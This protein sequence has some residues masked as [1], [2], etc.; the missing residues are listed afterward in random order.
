MANDVGNIIVIIT[1]ALFGLGVIAIGVTS[2]NLNAMYDNQPNTLIV[3][4]NDPTT[5]SED[6]ETPEDNFYETRLTN[7]SDDLKDID[8]S[9]KDDPYAFKGGKKNKSKKRK[10]KKS[11]KSKKRKSVKK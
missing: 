2:Y 8:N 5:D 7:L 6:E 1:G 11:K 4:K 10:S 9:E 3:K